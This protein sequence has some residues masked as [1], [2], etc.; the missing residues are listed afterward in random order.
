MSATDEAGLPPEKSKGNHAHP[1]FGRHMACGAFAMSIAV[2]VV[3]LIVSAILPQQ[4]LAL[5]D[6]I[7]VEKAERVSDLLFNNS[8]GY[9][10]YENDST[11][12]TVYSLDVAKKSLAS[13]D[14]L[15][16]DDES[17]N[18]GI[19]YIV[20]TSD[21]MKGNEEG[22]FVI[23]QTALWALM[24]EKDIDD[25]IIGGV[26]KTTDV[27]GLWENN[28]DPLVSA[29]RGMKNDYPSYDKQRDFFVEEEGLSLSDHDH[30]MAVSDDGQYFVSDWISVEGGSGEDVYTVSLSSDEAEIIDAK[31]VPREKLSTKEPFCVRVPVSADYPTI[32]VQVVVSNHPVECAQVYATENSDFERM[33]QLETKDIGLVL[34][35]TLSTP[36]SDGVSKEALIALIAAGVMVAFTGKKLW[37]ISSSAIGSLQGS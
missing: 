28:I 31:G 15:T 17:W 18:A 37:R 30:T 21:F 32:N 3:A 10:R 23:R 24:D 6:S 2:T 22:D 8:Y 25:R 29:A 1:C 27:Y 20:Q 33:V 12:E 34:S 19:Q 7:T 36:S 11:H 26:S 5:S 13:G 14:T 4:L 9:T 35:T 16:A